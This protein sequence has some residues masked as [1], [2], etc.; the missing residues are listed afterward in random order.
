MSR[1]LGF[2]QVAS[3]HGP[4][5]DDF[6]VFVHV[7]MLL[8][9]LGWGAWY[10][11]ALVRFRRTRSPAADYRGIRNLLPF[12]P[13]AILAIAEASLLV[14]FALPF[15]R[16]QVV[17]ASDDPDAF[18]VRV[19]GQQFQWNVHYP[20]PDGVFGRT[21][22]SLVDD[23]LNSVGLDN[24]DPAGKDDITTL[25]QLHLPANTPIRIQLGSKDVIHSFFLPEFRVKQDAIPGMFIPVKFTPTLT[26]AE[27]RARAGN[28][29]RDFEIACAQLCGIN[30]YTM[31][32][33]VTIESR[34]EFDAW[35]AAELETKAQYAGEDDWWFEEP[36]AAEPPEEPA[37]QQ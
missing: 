29:E 26:T 36:T 28:P 13:V 11:A 31:R 12:V 22:P 5:I 27:F 19:I 14:G 8:A 7:I 23:V 21:H 37:P 35:Y 17:S 10:A 1:W 32:G 16:Q 24:D 3:V 20:G 4:R 34:D 9:F 33:F 15:W 30:H 6:I 25:N 18:V 2:P